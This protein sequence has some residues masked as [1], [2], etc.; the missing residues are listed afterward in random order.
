MA[1][2]LVA[3]S[4][5]ARRRATLES[6]GAC[7]SDSAAGRC[8]PSKPKPCDARTPTTL[9]SVSVRFATL[10]RRTATSRSRVP[11]AA[12]AARRRV[13]AAV[14]EVLRAADQHQQV[15]A[16][17]GWRGC[18]RAYRALAGARRPALAARARSFRTAVARSCRSKLK[19]L[20]CLKY[21]GMI[22]A[23]SFSGSRR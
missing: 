6:S 16:A 5:R 23:A 10:E 4:R 17:D 22:S 15:V 3:P 12:G 7:V 9:S 1:I 11:T 13:G 19:R 2:F 21:W 20:L 8:S 18:A 14:V